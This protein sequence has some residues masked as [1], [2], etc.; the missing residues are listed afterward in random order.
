M[1]IQAL[2]VF[3]GLTIALTLGVLAGT[4]EVGAPLAGW[5]VIGL[6]PV[7]WALLYVTERVTGREIWQYTAPYPYRWMEAAGAT[8][9]SR[10]QAAPERELTE[11]E[12]ENIRLAA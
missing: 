9:A 6:V 7:L 1:G 12:A 4:L 10:L 5:L 2:V 3:V 8:E 11:V